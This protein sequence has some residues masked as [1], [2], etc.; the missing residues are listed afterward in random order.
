ML[1]HTGHI[2]AFHPSHTLFTL[3]QDRHRIS[4]LF[5]SD[6]SQVLLFISP[7]FH[8]ESLLH[9]ITSRIHISGVKTGGSKCISPETLARR[10]N[11]G[12][13]TAKRTIRANTQ[14]G[15]RTVA[16]PSLSR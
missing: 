1:D 15:V 3:Q 10:W 4:E 5:V 9:Q 14:R 8:D 16:H 2:R 7:F 12:L 6:T 13:D 11:I